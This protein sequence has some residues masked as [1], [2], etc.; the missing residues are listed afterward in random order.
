MLDI[1]NNKVKFEALVA[2]GD[3][4]C[5]S[6]ITVDRG[7]IGGLKFATVRALKVLLWRWRDEG[8][9]G[10]TIHQPLLITFLIQDV[11]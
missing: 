8:D 1:G 6:A 5:H 2:N 4:L 9:E 10:A 3:G 7:S 11:K